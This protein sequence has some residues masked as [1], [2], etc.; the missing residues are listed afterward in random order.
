MEPELEV[1]IRYLSTEEGGRKRGIASG[2]RGQFYY[3]GRDWCASQQLV[4][5]EICQPGETARVC[6][7]LLRPENHIGMFHV[8]Q[9]FEI[10]EGARTVARGVIRKIL[11]ADLECTIDWKQLKEN[12]Y[13]ED[14]S[15]RDIYVSGTTGDDWR[16]WTEWVQRTFSTEWSVGRTKASA[17]TVDFPMISDRWKDENASHPL[18]TLT[19]SLDH[20]RLNAHFFRAGEIENDLDPADM[21]TWGDHVRL[22]NYMKVMSYVLEKPVVLTPENTPDHALMTVNESESP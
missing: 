1:E 12:L 11:R 8:G 21:Q 20:I 17:G 22:L 19:V 10:R 14:G 2:Y 13:F 15:L 16:K 7:T 9:E 5:K 4:D 3:Y 18:A 6:L